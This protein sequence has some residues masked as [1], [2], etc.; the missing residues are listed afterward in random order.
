MELLTSARCKKV[1]FSVKA[2]IQNIKVMGESK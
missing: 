1:R 2:D